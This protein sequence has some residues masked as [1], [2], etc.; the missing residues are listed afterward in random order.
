MQT[1][2]VKSQQEGSRP[3]RDW[4]HVRD[5]RH[6]QRL[7][8]HQGWLLVKPPKRFNLQVDDWTNLGAIQGPITK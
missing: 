7:C 6:L 1:W 5:I 8:H 3:P 2:A 4:G